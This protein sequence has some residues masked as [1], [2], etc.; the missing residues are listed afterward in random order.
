LKQALAYYNAGIVAVN[1]KKIVGLAPGLLYNVE[2]VG[3]INFINK[4]AE[5]VIALKATL[6]NVCC[7][8]VHRY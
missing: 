8:S 6:H 5:N 3:V 1:F 4:L 7:P 2:E